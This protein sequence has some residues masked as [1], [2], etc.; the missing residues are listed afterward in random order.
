MKPLIVKDLMLK[1]T[2]YQ[3][4]LL[5]ITMSSSMQKTFLIKQLIPI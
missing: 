1:N 3:K 4:E 2:I 5:I